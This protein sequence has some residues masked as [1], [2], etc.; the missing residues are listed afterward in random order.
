MDDGMTEEEDIFGEIGEDASNLEVHE[1]TS[2]LEYTISG[3]VMRIVYS[4]DDGSYHVIR[5]MDMDGKEQTLVGAL[6]GIM[7]GQDIEATGRWELHREHGRQFR[8]TSF[9]RVRTC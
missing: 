1:T 8:V 5:L 2:Q 3:E 7:E 6:P 9:Q 4:N